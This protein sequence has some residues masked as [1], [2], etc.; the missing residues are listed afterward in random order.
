MDV[1]LM[2]PPAIPVIGDLMRHTIS[3]LI[4]RLLWRPMLKVMFS[5]SPVPRYFDRFPTWMALRPSQLR[6]SAEEAAIVIPSAMAL[7]RRYTE[8]AVPTVIVAGTQDR[9]VDHER[10][11][12]KL[13]TM[14]PGS[15]LLLSA[16]AGHM[17]HHA[18]PRRVLQALEAAAR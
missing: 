6:A 13:S 7:Q 5:P 2:A 14:I 11:S 18:D 15:E 16:R 12:V 1:P 4:G 17:V 8:I 9:Y 10:H 3:P